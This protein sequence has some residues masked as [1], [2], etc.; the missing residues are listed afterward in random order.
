MRSHS[1]RPLPAHAPLAAPGVRMARGPQQAS[2]ALTQTLI[3]GSPPG[4]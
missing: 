3:G 4:L 2:L 1:P